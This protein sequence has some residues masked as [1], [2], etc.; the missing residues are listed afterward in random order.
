MS[1]ALVPLLNFETTADLRPLDAPIGQ[2]RALGAIRF[3][4]QILS[5][6]IGSEQDRALP[7]NSSDDEHF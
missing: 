6:V 1:L 5:S 4:T 3:G 7:V 2:Q